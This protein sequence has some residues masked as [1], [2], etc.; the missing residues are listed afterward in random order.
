MITSVFWTC[1]QNQCGYESGGE[2][3]RPPGDSVSQTIVFCKSGLYCVRNIEEMLPVLFPSKE[4]KD[5]NITFFCCFVHNTV[6]P[7]FL[8][9]GILYFAKH[10]LLGV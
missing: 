9:S 5:R 3:L 4:Y 10:Y 7:R 2:I 6:Y 1:I 8:C